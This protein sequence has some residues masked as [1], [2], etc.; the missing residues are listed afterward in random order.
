MICMKSK[1]CK[2][3][4]MP[5]IFNV[6]TLLGKRHFVTNLLFMIKKT[7]KVR[8]IRWAHHTMM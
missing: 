8:V 2:I 7:S 5:S 1:F 3:V 4:S 6:V